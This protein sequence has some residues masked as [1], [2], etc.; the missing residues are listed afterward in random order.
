M[1]NLSAAHAT[2]F[3]GQIGRGQERANSFHT[4]ESGLDPVC[5]TISPLLDAIALTVSNGVLGAEVSLSLLKESESRRCVRVDT[6]GHSGFLKLFAQRNHADRLRYVRERDA[7]TLLKGKAQV[8]RHLAHYDKRSLILTRWQ[9]GRS[10]SDV[11]TKGNCVNIARSLGQFLASYEAVA[12]AQ[13]AAGNWYTYLCGIQN[14]LGFGPIHQAQDVLKDIPLCGLSLAQNDSALSN[15]IVTP[16]GNLKFCDFE[17]AVFKPRGWSY[18]NLYLTLAQRL[19]ER[20]Q[21]IMCAMAEGYSSAH[22]GAVLASELN[23]VANVLFCGIAA[24]GL[25]RGSQ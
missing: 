17:S 25:P 8:V 1:T 18:L 15:I 3:H 14:G 24:N 12:P 9:P 21:D 7:L 2:N 5:K 4:F 23:A 16:E 11:I 20:A 6:G 19:P 22:R 13:P 10:L